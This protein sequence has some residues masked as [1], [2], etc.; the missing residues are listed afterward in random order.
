MRRTFF[1]LLTSGLGL[2]ILLSLGIWQLQRLAWK[3][4]ILAEIEAKIAAAPTPLPHTPDPEADK[5]RPVEISGHFEPGEIHVITS[6]K[7]PGPGYRIIAAF[8]TDDGRR[9][10]VERGFVPTRNKRMDR[11]LGAAKLIGNLHWPVEVDSFTPTPDT[12][13]NVWYA[14][15]VVP[16]AETLQTDPILVIQRTD[17]T[18]GLRLTPVGIDGIANDH[19]QYALTWFSLAF[20]WAAMTAYFLWRMRAT[21]KGS[22]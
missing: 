15:D 22:T 6:I 4:G 19:L 7:G 18:S 8:Q 10:M 9:I 13:T 5:Y 11:P 1:F 2:V 16:M 3:E 12:G 14:R 20:I 21:S 17:P